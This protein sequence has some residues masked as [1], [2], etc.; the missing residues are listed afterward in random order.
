MDKSKWLWE[1]SKRIV[2]VCS[3]LYVCGFFYTCIAMWVWKDF[4]YLGTFIEQISDILKTCVFGYFIKA[5]VENVMKIR[6]SYEN[7]EDGGE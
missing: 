4:A 2:L 1:F 7:S 6:E 5:G 3:I